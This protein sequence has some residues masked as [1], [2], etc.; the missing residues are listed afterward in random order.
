MRR[1][2]SDDDLRLMTGHVDVSMTDY[3]DRSTALDHLPKLLEN[4]ATIDT[5]FS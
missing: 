3:Y 4:K 2:I 5:I 1:E